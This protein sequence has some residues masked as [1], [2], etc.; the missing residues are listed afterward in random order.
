MFR[1]QEDAHGYFLLL[2]QIV[3]SHGIPLDLYRD[4]HGIF[5]RSPRE[6]ETLEKSNSPGS[7]NPPRSGEP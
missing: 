4:R 1:Q 5:Q 7:A 3:R 2:R 6:V